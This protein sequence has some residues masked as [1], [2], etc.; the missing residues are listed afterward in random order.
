MKLI[1]LSNRVVLE[2]IVAEEVT[3]CGIIIP[4]PHKEKLQKLRIV[5]IGPECNGI[6]PGQEVICTK[7]TGTDI[8]IDGVSYLIVKQEDI[9]SVLGES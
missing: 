1:P 6:S 2:Q 3:K 4:N 8:E 7:Y 5:S 9:I